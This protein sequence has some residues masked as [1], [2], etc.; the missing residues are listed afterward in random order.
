MAAF[1]GFNC[2]SEDLAKG[3]HHMQSGGDSLKFYLSNA[4]PDAANDAVIADLA[5]FAGGNGYTAGGLW[6]RNDVSRS[7]A[8]TSLTGV[9]Q[10][11]AAGADW[12][13][14]FRYVVNSNAT[15]A[16]TP[17]INWWDYGVG[18]LTL[19]NGETFT[20]DVGANILT[21]APAA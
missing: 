7:T 15:A 1:N 3:I 16:N 10:T 21:I 5:E 18:G 2:F 8:T 17:L 9:D 11:W 19:A 4:T 6:Y 14:T 12:T 20:V 13:N